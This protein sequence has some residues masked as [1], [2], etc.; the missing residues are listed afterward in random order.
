MNLNNN[1]IISCTF[2]GF[3][4][5]MYGNIFSCLYCEDYTGIDLA[6]QVIMLILL[7]VQVDIS[8]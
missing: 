5:T 7:L 8:S 1:F 3:N 6:A 4:L 2:T